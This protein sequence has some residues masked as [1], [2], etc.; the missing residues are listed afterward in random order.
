MADD[1][2]ALYLDFKKITQVSY[3]NK[4]DGED[5]EK[6]D[7]F[8]DNCYAYRFNSETFKVYSMTNTTLSPT[9]YSIPCGKYPS[10]FI[11]TDMYLITDNGSKIQLDFNGTRV[12]DYNVHDL[13]TNLQWTSL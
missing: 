5:I 1:S 12:F 9:S 11:G 7:E 4:F 8:A 13:N 10:M 3:T 2:I 6:F